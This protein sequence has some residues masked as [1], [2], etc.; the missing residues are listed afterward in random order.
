MVRLLFLLLGAR[1]LKP[2]WR[3]LMVAGIVWMAL[4]ALILFDLSDGVLTVVQDTFA[5]FLVI[6][7]R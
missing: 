1:A 6:E 2:M 4:G 5:F 7:G 3:Y